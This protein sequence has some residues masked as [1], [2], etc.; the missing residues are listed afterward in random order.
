M[1]ARPLAILAAGLVA[2][3]VA[4]PGLADKPRKPKPTLELLTESQEAVLRNDAVKVRVESRRG[5]KA[6][7]EARLIVDGFP[8]DFSFRLG[9]ESGRLRGDAAKLKLPL[10]ARQREVLA[11]A[12]QACDRADLELEVRAGRAK[13]RVGK[14]LEPKS[15][16]LGHPGP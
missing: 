16:R 6:R 2:L 12:E 15:C 8:D 14:P 5:R 10:S 3:A 7:V 13:S 4:G 9:P 1:P 11:F